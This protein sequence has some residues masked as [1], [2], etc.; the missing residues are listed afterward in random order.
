MYIRT[1]LKTE[2][3]N[4]GALEGLVVPAPLVTSVLLVYNDL[5]T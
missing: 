5:F 2:S 1:P 4:S 3:V